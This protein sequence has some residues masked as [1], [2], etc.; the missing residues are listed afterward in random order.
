MCK[1]FQSLNFTEV[2]DHCSSKQLGLLTTIAMVKTE[3]CGPQSRLVNDAHCK[4]F[5]HVTNHGL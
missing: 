3:K 5:L 1:I 4:N 2:Q